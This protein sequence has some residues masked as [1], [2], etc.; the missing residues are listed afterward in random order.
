MTIS[1]L[2]ILS[3]GLAAA[4]ILLIIAV[5]STDTQQDDLLPAAIFEVRIHR[6]HEL[7]TDSV[8]I[9]DH[10]GRRHPVTVTDDVAI[11]E[12]VLDYHVSFPES[13]AKHLSMRIYDERP[14][15]PADDPGAKEYVSRD[16]LLTVRPRVQERSVSPFQLDIEVAPGRHSE[17]P[18]RVEWQVIDRLGRRNFARGARACPER[19]TIRFVYGPQPAVKVELAGA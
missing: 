2:D 10:Q 12:K 13:Y 4:I 1:L 5:T 14:F 16:L 9:L 7:N 11:T 8:R 17:V 6:Q 3:C 18:F 15:E 19:C